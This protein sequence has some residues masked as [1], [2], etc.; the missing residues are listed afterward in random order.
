VRRAD[1]LN[2]FMCRLSRKFGN[3]KNLQHEGLLQACNEV[4]LSHFS[5][6]YP[7]CFSFSVS[8]MG[9]YT[10]DVIF[11][12][13]FVFLAW[14]YFFNVIVTILLQNGALMLKALCLFLAQQPSP[15]PPQWARASSLKKILDHTQRRTTVGRTP[16]KE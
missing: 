8:L 15:P 16:P 1:N 12:V 14:M 13:Y 9:I 3:L 7:A 2:T 10:P 6:L 4:A 11:K 5:F